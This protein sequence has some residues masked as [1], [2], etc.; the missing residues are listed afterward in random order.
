MLEIVTCAASELNI[1]IENMILYKEVGDN[2]ENLECVN[3]KVSSMQHEK[4]KIVNI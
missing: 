1:I 4:S 3:K 2:R